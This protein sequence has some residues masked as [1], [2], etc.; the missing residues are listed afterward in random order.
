MHCESTFFMKPYDECN[1]HNVPKETIK[2]RSVYQTDFEI[3]V[4]YDKKPIINKFLPSGVGVTKISGDRTRPD[5]VKYL[6]PTAT[7]SNLT[8]VDHAFNGIAAK[9]NITFWNWYNNGGG[10]VQNV[11]QCQEKPLCNNCP[12]RRYEYRNMVKPVPHTGMT[13]E[14]RDNFT[15]HEKDATI[16]A[17]PLQRNV[18]SFEHV[19]FPTNTENRIYGSGQRIQKYVDVD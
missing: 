19:P 12:N 16:R 13:T 7:T 1:L 5:F 14:I 17:C 9:D 3:K 4:K 10:F 11:W 6:D 2:T 15:P 18:V 8:Y